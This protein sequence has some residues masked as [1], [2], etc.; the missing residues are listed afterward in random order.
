MQQCFHHAI[1][2]RRVTKLGCW[3]GAPAWASGAVAE[4][5]RAEFDGHLASLAVTVEDGL[6]SEKRL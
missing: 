2:F 4:S 5:G 3:N 6:D 1:Q